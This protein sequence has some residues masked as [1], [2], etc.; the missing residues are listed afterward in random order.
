MCEGKDCNVMEK[1]IQNNGDVNYC[2]DGPN[3]NLVM[4]PNNINGLDLNNG[5]SCNG[6]DIAGPNNEYIEQNNSGMDAS[7]GIKMNNLQDN[8]QKREAQETIDE[9]ELM[10]RRLGEI[11]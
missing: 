1:T 6:K 3:V 2:A 9:L 11:K 8:L 10:G 5:Y 7:Y 4:G